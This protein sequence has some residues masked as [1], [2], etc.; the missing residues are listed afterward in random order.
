M[1]L[2]LHGLEYVYFPSTCSC[3][4][5]HTETWDVAPSFDKIPSNKFGGAHLYKQGGE[6]HFVRVQSSLASAGSQENIVFLCYLV[7]DP[8][9]CESICILLHLYV[10]K[11]QSFASRQVHSF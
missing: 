6:G 2:A 10:S 7:S 3:T 8:Y 5:V 4:A 1:S 9:S 11:A